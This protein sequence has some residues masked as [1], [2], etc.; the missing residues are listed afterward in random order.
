[1]DLENSLSG[2]PVAAQAGGSLLAAYGQNQAGKSDM[3]AAQY[4]SASALQSAGQAQAVAQVR[5]GQQQRDTQLLLSKENAAAAGSGGSADSPSVARLENATANQGEYNVLTSLYN[6][7][8]QARALT[9]ESNAALYSGSEQQRAAK[10]LA[11]SSLIKGGTSLFTKYGFKSLA[12][13]D[14][15]DSSIPNYGISRTYGGNGPG[16]G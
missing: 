4:N 5:A 10:V 16:Y 12:P 14:Q 11:A 3:Q 7:D 2:L 8:E 13:S 15:I 9:N 6:G 1:M